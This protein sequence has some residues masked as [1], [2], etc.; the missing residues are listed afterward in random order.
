VLQRQ[1]H[2]STTLP[3]T[4]NDELKIVFTEAHP[5]YNNEEMR[6][7]AD[8]LRDIMPMSYEVLRCCSTST[9]LGLTR[10]PGDGCGRNSQLFYA[11]HKCIV[12]LL[13][14]QVQVV[15]EEKENVEAQAPFDSGP[16]A[17]LRPN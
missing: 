8:E 4:L 15:Q 14:F 16:Q 5:D 3:Q 17:A 2:R 6:A 7:R 12:R 10:I 1:V 11:V 9:D 13:G